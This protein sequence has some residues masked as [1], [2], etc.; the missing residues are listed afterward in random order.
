MRAGR[1]SNFRRA[2]NVALCVSIALIAAAPLAAQG[3]QSEC[4][5]EVVEPFIGR[6]YS[7]ADLPRGV[8][9]RVLGPNSSVPAVAEPQTLTIMVDRTGKITSVSCG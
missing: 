4:R 8:K 1:V 7:V 6:A 3:Q 5:K 2:M 9:I